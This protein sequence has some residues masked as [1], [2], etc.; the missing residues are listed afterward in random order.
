MPPD[1]MRPAPA[2]PPCEYSYYEYD[3]VPYSDH[4]GLFWMEKT[5]KC[6]PN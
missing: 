1:N 6:D 2:E 4:P 5:A 3:K